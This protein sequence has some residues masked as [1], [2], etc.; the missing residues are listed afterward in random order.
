M[1]HLQALN[2]SFP[3]VARCT[4]LEPPCWRAEAPD[5]PRRLAYVAMN[6]DCGCKVTPSR[7]RST[8]VCPIFWGLFG[9]VAVVAVLQSKI[10]LSTP[11]KSPTSIYIDV[12]LSLTFFDMV[13]SNCNTATTA[14]ILS[15][16]FANM[17]NNH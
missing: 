11:T 5:F 13:K 3:L 7:L 17:K 10:G 12:E 14:T 4:L 8:N 16:L 9:A 6:R 15:R 1:N 2:E